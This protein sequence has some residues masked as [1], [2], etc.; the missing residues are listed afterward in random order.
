[1]PLPGCPLTQAP[2]AGLGAGA[3]ADVFARAGSASLGALRRVD[4]NVYGV[5]RRLRVGERVLPFREVD[6]DGH[7]LLHR[8]EGSARAG[9]PFR[10]GTWSLPLHLNGATILLLRLR[11]E[12]RSGVWNKGKC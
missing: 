4:D 10:G 9:R 8:G 12:R 6:G 7:G 2:E 1:M 3:F 5:S 11:V